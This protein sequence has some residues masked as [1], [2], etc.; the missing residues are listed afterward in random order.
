M[1]NL[2]NKHSSMEADRLVVLS[3]S[4]GMSIKSSLVSLLF[5]HVERAGENRN[6]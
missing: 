3:T 4:K 6:K 2:S 5:F 1:E